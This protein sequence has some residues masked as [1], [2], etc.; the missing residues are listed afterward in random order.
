MLQNINIKSILFLDI[1]T[2]PRVYLFEDLDER[3][4]ELW[5]KKSKYLIKTEDDT[6]ASVYEKAGIYAEFGKVVCVCAAYIAEEDGKEVLKQK[7]YADKE[8]KDLLQNFFEDI[9]KLPSQFYLCGHNAREFDI[10]FLCRRGLVNGLKLP[11][12]LN[13]SGKKPWEV[14]HLDTLDLWKFGDYKHY[15]SL[16]LLAYV[17]DIPTPKDDI[18]GSM[19]KKIYWEDH[20]LERIIRYCEKDVLTL[21]NLYR[22]FSGLAIMKP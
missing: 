11:T 8:E 3:G 18:D 4:K 6:P 2:A 19:V 12:L 20:D 17:F 5:T 14:Q 21:V 1:E 7:T 15:T 16:D 9:N 13:L 10:P 22:K